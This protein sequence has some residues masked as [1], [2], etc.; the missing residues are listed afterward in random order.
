MLL[1][2]TIALTAIHW[3]LSELGI[4][5]SPDGLETYLSGLGEYKALFTGTIAVCGA[6]FG[7]QRAKVSAEANREKVKQDYFGEWKTVIQVR[8]SEVDKYDKRMLREIVKI[9]HSLYNDLYELNM[10]IS[11]KET[12][13]KIFDKHVKS[14]VRFF[15]EQNDKYIGMG[16][17]YR[18]ADNSYSYDTFRFIFLGMIDQGYDDLES[19]LKRLYL[20][21]ME[22]NRTIDLELFLA[23]Q[24]IYRP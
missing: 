18:I 11:N 12:L 22:G 7:L 16:G 10:K 1:M 3:N 4:D 20:D 6:Y 9:R 8:A 5:F 17:A 24:Q 13:T 21:N 19:D 2:S 14:R 23:A 15:E